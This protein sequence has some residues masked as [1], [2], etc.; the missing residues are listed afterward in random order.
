MSLSSSGQTAPNFWLNPANGV[1]YTV[2]VMTPQYKMG[3]L[4]ELQSTPVAVTGA[5]STAA[6][7]QPRVGER[8]A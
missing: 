7:R 5:A 6:L 1:Q 8:A 2:S 3:S 4:D